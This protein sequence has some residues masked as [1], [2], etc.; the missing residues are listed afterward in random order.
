[1]SENVQHS[2]RCKDPV[3]ILLCSVLY[4]HFVYIMCFD[5]G[6][7]LQVTIQVF[8]QHCTLPILDALQRDTCSAIIIEAQE[9][10]SSY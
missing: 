8:K 2:V 5:C 9:C 4:Q 3:T 1:M 7:Q 6:S 10:H